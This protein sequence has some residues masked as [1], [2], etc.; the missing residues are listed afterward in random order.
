VV[1]VPRASL[2]GVG[3][4]GIIVLPDARVSW[5]LTPR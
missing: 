5:L 3:I 1:G 2:L 4:G